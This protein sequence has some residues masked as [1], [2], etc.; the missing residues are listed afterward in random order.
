IDCCEI[1]CNPAC[2]GCLND[3][4]GLINGDR[5]IRAQHVC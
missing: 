2:F 3:A 1:C 5:P 4:N